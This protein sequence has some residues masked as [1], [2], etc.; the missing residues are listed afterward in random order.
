MRK[1]KILFTIGSFYLFFCIC[2]NEIYAQNTYATATNLGTLSCAG[3][4]YTNIAS[5]NTTGAGNECGNTAPDR[6]YRFTISAAAD[7]TISLCNSGFDTYLRLYN[8]GAANCGAATQINSNDD[9]CGLQSSIAQNG[10]VAGTYIVMVEGYGSDVGVYQLDI[11]ISNCQNS[12]DT[13]CDAI[14]VS[15]AC[16]AKTI[17]NN[18]AKTNSGIGNPS[19]GTYSGGDVWYTT[20]IPASGNLS[21]ELK[22]TLTGITDVGLAAYTATSCAGPFT[23]V[24]CSNVSMP[25][26]NLSGLTP[27]NTLYTRVWENG[28]NQTGTFEVEIKNPSNLFCLTNN[29]SMFNYPADT[30]VQVTPNL[31][32]QKGCAWYQGTIDFSSS[33]DH[34]LQVYCGNNDGGA[35][36]LTF[37]FHNDPQGTT[38]CGNDGQYLGAGGIQ[39]AVV[40]EID[41]WDNGGS[42][43]IAADHV[44]VWTSVGGEGAPIA[45]PVSAT[46]PASN[47]EDGNTHNLRITWNAATK[48]MQVYFDGVLRLT[49]SND[50]VTNVFGSNNVFWGS[51]GSTGGASNQYYVCPPTSLVLPIK[52]TRYSLMCGGGNAELLW[53]TAAEINNDYF[54]IERSLDAV[55]FEEVGTVKGAGNSNENINYNW[56]DNNALNGISYYRLKQTDYNGEFSYSEIKTA[57]CIRDGD[58]SVYPNPFEDKLSI[59]LSEG[60]NYPIN[61]EIIDFLGRKVYSKYI[62]DDSKSL[63]LD[64]KEE[65]LVG[66]YFIQIYNETQRKTQKIIRQN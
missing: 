27:G 60:F 43:E 47:I 53:T 16:G 24:G 44:A 54:T 58:F 25:S 22:S 1:I 7:V 30:C 5:G 19:C 61:I 31:T 9:A 32:S 46:S 38:E 12:G 28:N 42:Q 3:S 40:I 26:L 11:T 55:S 59:Q 2:G 49:V 33:F 34:S 29:A 57:S 13:P 62:E 4:P 50:F 39:N 36:G 15:T 52:L 8:S 21:V 23:Q 45:G 63:D 64:L 18:I 6:W 35:D 56:V 41:T 37:T 10:L 66:A 65:H 17:G 14:G 48:T 20:V 51:T